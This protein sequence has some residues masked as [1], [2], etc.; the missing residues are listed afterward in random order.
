MDNIVDLAYYPLSQ[1]E[2]VVKNA[3]R[4]GLGTMGLADYLFKK[5]IRYGSEKCIQELEKLYKFIRDEAYKASIELAKEKGAFPKFNKVDYCAASYIRK[6]PP[7][8]RLQIK[9]HAIRNATLLTCAP[10]GTTALLVNVVGGIEPLPFKGYRRVDGVGERV[11]ISDYCKQGISEDWFVDS[12]DLTPEEHLEVQATIQKY[13]DASV[14]KTILLP[15]K[16]KA[17]DLDTIL[18]EY[19]HDL[20]GVTVYRNESRKEQVYYRLTNK[21]IKRHLQNGKGSANLEADLVECKGGACD[22]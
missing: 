18:M 19:I 11:Y 17:K 14:S 3:R 7:K 22:I 21:E 20:K 2:Q 16:T 4:I 12:Y 10:T 5:K 15:T 8:L 1:Q 13:M 6:L 9:E